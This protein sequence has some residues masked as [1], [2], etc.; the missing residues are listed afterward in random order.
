M[1]ASLIAYVAIGIVFWLGTYLEW[2]FESQLAR[3]SSPKIYILT[4]IIALVCFCAAWWAVVWY[5]LD[6]KEAYHG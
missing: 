2:H 5:E 3:E 1:Q 6:R 4:T